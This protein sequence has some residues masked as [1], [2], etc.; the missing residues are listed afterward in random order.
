MVAAFIDSVFVRK[1]VQQSL[2]T[3]ANLLLM[4]LWEIFMIFPEKRWM[5][6]V[7]SYIQDFLAAGLFMGSF[8]GAYMDFYYSFPAYDLVMHSVG[9]VLCTFVGYEILVCMQKRDKVKV[10]LPIVIFGA[11]GIS[12]FAGTAWELFEFVF[13][14]VAPQIGDAQHWSLA[15]AEKAAEEHGI[16]L[17]NVE[18]QCAMH[19]L[20]P[21]RILCVIR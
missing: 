1:D 4:F 20:I 17:P 2:Q 16:G 12:F 13:D 15:L 8:G 9:G 21:W 18:I 14:Q 11:F 10:D 7:P 19:L 6:Y 3:A 5:H